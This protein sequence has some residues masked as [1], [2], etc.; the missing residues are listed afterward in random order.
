M[1]E[2][3]FILC[4][5][6]CEH[7]WEQYVVSI[8]D[9]DWLCPKCNSKEEVYV[10]EYTPDDEDFYKDNISLGKGGALHA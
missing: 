9:I 1:E 10:I 7:T 2:D 6:K 4:C 5:N 3:L 8:F